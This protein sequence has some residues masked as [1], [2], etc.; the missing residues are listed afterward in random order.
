MENNNTKKTALYDYHKK[1]NGNIINFNG[2]YLPVF[3]S[4]IKLEHEA[5]RKNIGLFDVSHM[6]NIILNFPDKITSINFFNYLLANDF[7]KIFPCKCIYSTM[8]NH[9][10]TVIDDLIVMSLNETEYHIIVNASNIDK[11]YNWI[12]NNIQNNK[13]NLE[14]KSDFYSILAI[15]GPNSCI[16]LEKEFNFNFKNLKPFMIQK[17]NWNNNELLIARTGYTGEDGFELIFNKNISIN[18]FDEIIKKGEKYNLLPCGLGAR[19]T[20]RLEA[21]LPLY[22]HELDD[23]HSPLQT[24]IAWSV[25]LNKS[26][27]FIGKEALINDPLKQFNDKL[28]GFEL[29]G[30]SIPRHGM[31]ILS[32][33][34]KQIGYVTSG[35]FSPTLQKN[36]GIAYIKKEYLNNTELKIKIRDKIEKIELVNLPFYKKQN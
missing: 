8:L 33:D 30:K 10:G 29:I 7:S 31:M 14:N 9:D 5:V 13:I 32:N 34:E 27:D 28:M 3:Y 11:D 25:K 1:L 26:C 18:F 6:G 20:L 15:Q 35:S 12:K 36:I 16:F 24:N 23:K 2:V 22:G 4:S 21:S 17:F 19:D